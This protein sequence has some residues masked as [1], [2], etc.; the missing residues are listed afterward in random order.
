VLLCGC[1]GCCGHNHTTITNNCNTQTQNRH[2]H[3]T[4]HNYTRNLTQ[5][6]TNSHKFVHNYTQ[7]HTQ[8]HRIHKHQSQKHTTR[9]TSNTRTHSVSLGC[10]IPQIRGTIVP[11]IVECEHGQCVGVWCSVCGMSVCVWCVVCAGVCCLLWFFL[12]LF[13]VFFIFGVISSVFFGISA[14]LWFGVT[15]NSCLS[16]QQT[17]GLP[18]CCFWCFGGVLVGL[19]PFFEMAPVFGCFRGIFHPFL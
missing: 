9:H 8:L 13:F 11:Q 4:I 14:F 15:T 2:R 3:T 7:I 16:Y 12:W 18:F 17:S 5:L 19:Y 1:G 10:T 6:H